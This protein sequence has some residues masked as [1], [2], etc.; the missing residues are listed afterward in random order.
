M[1]ATLAL[2]SMVETT[3]PLI[4]TDGKARARD[5]TALRLGPNGLEFAADAAPSGRFAWLQFT[6]P[7]MDEPM[8]A[9]GE[10]VAVLGAAQGTRVLVRFKHLWP[11]DRARVASFL[12]NR[13]AA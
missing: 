1:S 10:V 11:C 8:K 9:L 12:E 2:D 3:F 13:A 7:G 5:A 4:E 6:L